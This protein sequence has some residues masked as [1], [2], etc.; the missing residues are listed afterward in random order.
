LAAD[1]TGDDLTV[2]ETNHAEDGTELV[3][4]NTADHI[5]GNEYVFQATAPNDL[6][7]TDAIRGIAEGYGNGVFGSSG[8]A[9]GYAGVLGRI[10]SSLGAGVRGENEQGAAVHGLSSPT[11]ATGPIGT[12]VRGE[13]RD[14]NNHGL[15][16]VGVEG[17]S[18]NGIGVRGLSGEP[19]DLA[20]GAIGVLGAADSA[21]GR[22]VRGQTNL[23]TGVQGWATNGVGIDAGSA[24]S[25]A[26][27]AASAR[28]R[29]GVFQSG[30]PSSMGTSIGGVAQLQLVPAADSA[31]PTNGHLGDV[32]AHFSQSVHDNRRKTVSL[33]LCVNDDP[34]EWE[35]IVLSG[36]R[37]AGG[38]SPP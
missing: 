20:T 6:L 33:W 10:R 25:V 22:G 8:Q 7:G 37:T 4:N 19:A 1:D 35:Q 14:P 36:V 23:G 17:I 27:N 11:D 29:A 18:T 32:W 16:G 2:G 31:L 5:F 9:T 3:G 12:G 38:T 26:L 34:V 24:S 21:G 13:A 30:D 28:D 15:Q